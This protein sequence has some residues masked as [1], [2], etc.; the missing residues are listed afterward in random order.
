MKCAENLMCFEYADFKAFTAYFGTMSRSN[1]VDMTLNI[2][3]SL[4]YSKNGR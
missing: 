4:M 3:C 2:I 1:N